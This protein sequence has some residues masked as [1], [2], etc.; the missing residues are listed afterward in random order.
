MK[1]LRCAVEAHIKWLYDMDLQLRQWAD[2]SEKGGWS[3]HQVDVQRQKAN[4][5]LRQVRTLQETIESR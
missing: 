1:D 2:Q 5:V 3:T 4:D